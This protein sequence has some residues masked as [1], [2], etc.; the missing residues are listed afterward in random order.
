MKT[1]KADVAVKPVVS[2]EWNV[3][4]GTF[5][6][7][8]AAQRAALCLEMSGQERWKT[9]VPVGAY[10]MIDK[11]RIEKKKS[12]LPSAGSAPNKE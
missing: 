3:V 5:K 1:K 10:I 9:L 8:S 11:I 2:N 7:S 12:L 4:K 6:T